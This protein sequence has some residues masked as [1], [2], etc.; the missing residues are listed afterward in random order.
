MIVVAM[1]LMQASAPS[2]FSDIVR[3]PPNVAGDLVL[4]GQPHG[5]IEAVEAPTGGMN[6]PGMTDGQLV[7]QPVASGPGCIR[8]RWTMRF[9]ARPDADPSTGTLESVAS[10]TEIALKR[11]GGCPA[12]QYVHLNPGVDTEQGFDALLELERIRLGTR[13]VPITCTDRTSSDLCANDASTRLALGMVTPWAVSREFG[14]VLVWL[15]T[16]GRGS[17]TEARFN[18]P[19]ADYL[20]VRRS[21]PAPF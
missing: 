19:V 17:L 16:P 18:L 20:I 5:R 9:R 6:A 7:E 10:A 14:D 12:G 8:R 4:H 3:L 11:L 13:R 1:L 15:G 2:T 21:I